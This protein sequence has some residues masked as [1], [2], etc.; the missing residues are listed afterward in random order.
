MAKE[1]DT[2]EIMAQLEN[3]L[4]IILREVGVRVASAVILFTPIGRP[5][6]TK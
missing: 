4:Q 6:R 2:D 3:E 5:D 1:F